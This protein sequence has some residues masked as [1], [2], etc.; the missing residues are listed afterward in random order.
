MDSSSTGKV[1]NDGIW[2]LEFNPCLLQKLIGILISWSNDKELLSGTDT[3]DYKTLKK[4]KKY[5]GV[6]FLFG[7]G[8]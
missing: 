4:N 8:A 5:F 2:Y 1:S 7:F 3:I 6:F